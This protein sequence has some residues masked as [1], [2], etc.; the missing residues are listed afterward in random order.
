MD[1]FA[2]IGQNWS[3]NGE[4]FAKREGVTF[5][6]QPKTLPLSD[7][8]FNVDF[9]RLIIVLQQKKGLKIPDSVGQLELSGI[10]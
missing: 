9:D 1:I 4:W 7:A 8:E 10:Q 3:K 5:P 2:E 6:C